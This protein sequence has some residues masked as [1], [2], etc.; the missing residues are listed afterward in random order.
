MCVFSYSLNIFRIYLFSYSVKHL[1]SSVKLLNKKD[2]HLFH[3]FSILLRCPCSSLAVIVTHWLVFVP[4]CR[5]KVRSSVQH[6]V[7]QREQRG[8]EESEGVWVICAETQRPAAAEGLHRAAVHLTARQ[9]HGLPQRILRKAGKGL[10]L[11]V[12]SSDVTWNQQIKKRRWPQLEMCLL[13]QQLAR[14]VMHSHRYLFYMYIYLYSCIF[15]RRR[16]P[17]SS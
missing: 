9:T 3:L 16:K 7:R 14:A 5:S 13:K 8:G 6:G 1:F 2:R 11:F 12:Q 15:M 4:H 10:H 17:S